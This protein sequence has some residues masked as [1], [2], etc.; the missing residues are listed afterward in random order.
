ME[1]KYFKTCTM[2]IYQILF[3]KSCTKAKILVILYLWVKL[4]YTRYLGPF[5]QKFSLLEIWIARVARPNLENVSTSWLRRM[6]TTWANHITFILA[7][8]HPVMTFLYRD[9][10]KL[11]VYITNYILLYFPRWFWSHRL[12]GLWSP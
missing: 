4:D 11:L 7:S 9:Y 3:S 8:Q 2:K 1:S 10:S 5:H 6:R 12:L